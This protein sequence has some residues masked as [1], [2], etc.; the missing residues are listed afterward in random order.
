MWRKANAEHRT[1][2]TE[3]RRPEEENA[4]RSTPNVQR[5]MPEPPISFRILL[6]CPDAAKKDSNE[7]LI[8]IENLRH[9]SRRQHLGLKDEF[10]PTSSFFQL[11]EADL[12]FVDE[13][14][15]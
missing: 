4:Q 6:G 11:L 13:I 7:L 14:F 9:L 15:A 2:N 12:Q 8:L 10:Q 5:S 3:R 1:P